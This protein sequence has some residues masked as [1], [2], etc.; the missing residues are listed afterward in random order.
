MNLPVNPPRAAAIRGISPSPAAAPAAGGGG[1]PGSGHV[2]SVGF[3]GVLAGGVSEAVASV[4][5]VLGTAASSSGVGALWSSGVKQASTGC[6]RGSRCPPC[7]TLPQLDLGAAVLAQCSE[8]SVVESRRC[9]QRYKVEAL[10]SSRTIDFPSVWGHLLYP[11][12]VEGAAAARRWSVL[13]LAGCF[14]FAEGLGCNF[15]LCL[16]P[17]CNFLGLM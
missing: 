8:G 11:R 12:L 7:A 16:G 15:L 10:R 2:H 17:F 13:F 4:A 3:V 6:A 1:I 14:V 5:G 9:S